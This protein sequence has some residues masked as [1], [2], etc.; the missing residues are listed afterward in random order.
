MVIGSMGGPRI[1]TSVILT[2]LNYLDYGLQLQAAMDFPRI[3]E[4]WVPDQLFVEPEISF[5]VQAALR[6][7]G[8]AVKVQDPWAAVTAI[9]ADS[10][11][12]GWWGASDG[13]VDGLAKGF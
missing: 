6:A 12:G 8:H 3:H 7:R 5:D 2:I 13:R 9:A 4:Q 1:I 11:H 10:T